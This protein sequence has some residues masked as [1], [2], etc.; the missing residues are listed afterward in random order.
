MRVVQPIRDTD[1]IDQFKEETKKRSHRD[2]IMA[3][4][5]FNTGLRISD[6]VPLKVKDVKG[7]SHIT[8]YEKKTG[9]RKRFIINHIQQD[10][11]EYIKEEK[12][13]DEDY[14]FKSR[15]RDEN[16]NQRPISTTQAYRRLKA[17]AKDLGIEEF[18]T[19]SLRKSFSYHY[20]HNGGP[21]AIAYLMNILNHSSEAITLKYIGITED[22]IDDSLEGF[23]L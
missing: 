20:Y 22:L 14:L 21:N 5:G 15:N 16:G 7:K 10:I 2:Y 3:T 4:I 9:K 8:I 23:Y 6:I 12:L 1:I 18:G 11:S 17:V 13:Q 19:H